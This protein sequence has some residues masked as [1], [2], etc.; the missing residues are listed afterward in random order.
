[1]ERSVAVRRFGPVA[2]FVVVLGVLVALA[3]RP[4][5]GGSRDLAPLPLGATGGSR[6][7][8]A[9][10]AAAG[11]YGGG[12]IVIPDR[13]LAGLPTEAPAYD[14]TPGDTTAA[15]LTALAR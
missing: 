10:D 3:L 14:V 2:V 5:S 12:A 13:L 1:M 6:T 15:R 9:R 7:A 4:G 8:E 11:W